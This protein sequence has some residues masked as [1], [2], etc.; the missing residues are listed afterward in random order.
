[1]RENG[2]II[3]FDK[4]EVKP[5]DELN[6]I[7]KI[8]YQGRF[9]SIVINSQIENSSDIFT[10]TKLDGKKINY[11]YARMPI[12]R[13]DI[14]DGN[15][16]KFTVITAHIPQ[17]FSNVKFRASIIQEHKEVADDVAFVRIIP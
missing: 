2:I 8:N 5:K 16:I 9:D 14:K 10:F 6:G 13:H 17:R 3:N 1:M 12:L 7:I 15:E 11:S 4:N